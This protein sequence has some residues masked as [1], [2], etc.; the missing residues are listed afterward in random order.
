MYYTLSV[1]ELTDI[2]F[3]TSSTSITFAL[4]L[5]QDEFKYYSNHYNNARAYGFHLIKS[6]TII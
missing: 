3:L 6:T 5:Y 4:Y 2:T 1:K